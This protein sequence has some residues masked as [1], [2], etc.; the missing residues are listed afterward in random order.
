ME[1][2]ELKMISRVEIG[3]LC[4]LSAFPVTRPSSKCRVSGICRR[5]TNDFRKS[6]LPLLPSSGKLHPPSSFHLYLYDGK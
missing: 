2:M 6:L 1:W 4:A 3:H 5:E